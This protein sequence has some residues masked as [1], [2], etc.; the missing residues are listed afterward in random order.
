MGRVDQAI[1]CWCKESYRE[2]LGGDGGPSRNN[3]LLSLGQN[4]PV[5]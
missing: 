5:G 4:L 1:R 3:L 2:G